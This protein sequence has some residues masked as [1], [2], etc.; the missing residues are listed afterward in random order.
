ML[1]RFLIWFLTPWTGFSSVSAVFIHPI[2]PHLVQSPEKIHAKVHQAKESKLQASSM[3]PQKNG[4]LPCPIDA[5]IVIKSFISYAE[6][7]TFLQSTGLHATGSPVPH[8][9]G[10]HHLSSSI[11]MCALGQLGTC[12]KGDTGTAAPLMQGS[13]NIVGKT[14]CYFCSPCS[15]YCQKFPYPL[16]PNWEIQKVN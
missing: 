6:S 3:A 5:S 11:I 7:S 10:Q 2:L 9:N 16:A 8:Q 14:G 13:M 1:H 15:M 4:T 12:S